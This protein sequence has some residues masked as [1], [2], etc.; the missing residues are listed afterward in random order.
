MKLDKVWVVYDPTALS[1]EADILSE[2]TVET[3]CHLIIGANA[4]GR[5][6]AKMNASLYTEEA[7]ARE[8][9]KARLQARDVA[10][11]NTPTTLQ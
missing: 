10:V 2:C 5:P 6:M 9:A 4:I 3:L 8:D 7:E 1:E 11:R